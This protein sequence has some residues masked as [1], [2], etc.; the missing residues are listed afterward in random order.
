MRLDANAYSSSPTTVNSPH[1]LNPQV[2][3]NRSV[4]SLIKLLAHHTSPVNNVRM[5]A[6]TVIASTTDGWLFAWSLMTYQRYWARKAH[7]HAVTALAIFNGMV[8]SGG[9]DGGGYENAC[10]LDA[11]V[12]VWNMD[13]RDGNAKEGHAGEE[14]APS[15]TEGAASGNKAS[16]YGHDQR[17]TELGGPAEVVWRLGIVPGKLVVLVWKRGGVVLETWTEAK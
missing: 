17:C 16:E 11:H 9:K 14:S 3:D 5:H 7:D 10:G 12:R 15:F 2:A 1:I 4:R 8:V 6:S 13:D